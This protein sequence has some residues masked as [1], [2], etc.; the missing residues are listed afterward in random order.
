[1]VIKFKKLHELAEL[2]THAHQGDAGVD[3]KAVE[4]Q[5]DGFGNLVYKF[6]IAVE[7]PEGNVGLLFPR[8]SIHKKSQFL[9]NSVGVID[10][11]YRGEIMAKFKPS[12]SYINGEPEEDYKEED[13]VAQL[14][15]IPVRTLQTEWV[16]QLS[17]SPRG[18]S[19]YGS[20]G[21]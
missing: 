6:G 4:I 9:T 18:E 5:T 21:K 19:G 8:S 14:L 15:I 17:D 16:E 11:G 1:M 20:T 7:I 10:S 12:D 2:P 3:L 13:K